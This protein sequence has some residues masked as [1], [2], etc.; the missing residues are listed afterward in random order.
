MRLSRVMGVAVALTG[1]LLLP[2]P[3]A[4]LASTGGNDQAVPATPTAP[5]QTAPEQGMPTPDETAASAHQLLR[6]YIATFGTTSLQNLQSIMRDKSG[7]YVIRSAT[8]ATPR[9]TN[10]T[11]AIV[12]RPADFVQKYTNVDLEAAPGVEE[13]LA[14]T[15]ADALAGGLGIVGENDRNGT[16]VCSM[17]FNAFSP[18]G[19]P[20]ILSAG[21]CTADG[22]MEQVY[23]TDPRSDPAAD[24]ASAGSPIANPGFRGFVIQDRLGT[25]SFSQFGGEGNSPN[26]GTPEHPGNPGTDV[27]VI[28]G[29]DPADTQL[30]AVT[31]WEKPADLSSTGPLVTG[32][33]EPVLGAPVCKSGRTTGWTCGTI[34]EVGLFMVQGPN[35]SDNHQDIRVLKGSAPLVWTLPAEIRA[36]RWSPERSRLA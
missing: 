27:S 32:M 31:D 15:P 28:S 25:Y 5:T 13:P 33:T 30:P 1:S 21:H 36:D 23:L 7:G 9:A 16:F 19:I 12:P 17:G 4:S 34:D 26:S 6:D 2:A 3:A 24:S 35:Y 8:P 11:P 10:T 18:S 20:A 29:L 14:D 22:T